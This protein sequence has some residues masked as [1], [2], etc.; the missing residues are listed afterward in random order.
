M[1]NQSTMEKCIACG[2]TGHS[3][4]ACNNG[5]VGSLN[6]FGVQIDPK[7]D[8]SNGKEK[9]D[10]DDDRHPPVASNIGSLLRKSKSMEILNIYDESGS[11]ERGYQS[12]DPHVRSQNRKKGVTWTEEEHR[13][14]LIG[15]EKLGK[16][17]WRGISKNYVPSRTPTQ[18]ASHAQKY[19]IRMHAKQEKGKRRS[20][21]FD[22]P[23]NESSAAPGV[24]PVTTVRPPVAPIVRSNSI[25]DFNRLSYAERVFPMINQDRVFPMI[26]QE[27]VYPMINHYTE[28]FAALAPFKSPPLL[29]TNGDGMSTP[30]FKLDK[31]QD[32]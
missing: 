28:R 21:L 10:E 5:K 13:S 6:L 20:S 16:G 26:N 31:T 19:F 14:F 3:T 27:R 12:D 18:V 15:L 7:Q 17:D 30:E 32:E 29:I 23:S 25:E 9:V 1:A 2:Q 11:P 24:T 22:M 4:T 8:Q